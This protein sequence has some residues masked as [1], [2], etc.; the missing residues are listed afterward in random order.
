MSR[1]GVMVGIVCLCFG[2]CDGD[3]CVARLCRC[4][5]RYGGIQGLK[6]V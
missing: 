5:G 2:N 3:I 4:V 1:L 6:K